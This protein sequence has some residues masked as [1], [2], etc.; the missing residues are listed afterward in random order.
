MM[1]S[2]PLTPLAQRDA[3][4]STPISTSKQQ[5]IAHTTPPASTQSEKSG[6]PATPAE[7][8]IDRLKH[9]ALELAVTEMRKAMEMGMEDLQNQLEE[10]MTVISEEIATQRSELITTGAAV[11]EAL[12]RVE[13]VETT[14]AA[15]ERRGSSVGR[16]TKVTQ[17]AWEAEILAREK[18]ERDVAES[19]GAT[20]A[21]FEALEGTIQNQHEGFLQLI[22]LCKQL[23]TSN[24]QLESRIEQCEAD[25]A[26]RVE[27]I[28]SAVWVEVKALSQ[29]TAEVEARVGK[30]ESAAT[31]S[32]P[33]SRS[34]GEEEEEPEDSESVGVLRQQLVASLQMRLAAAE[35]RVEEVEAACSAETEQLRCEVGQ[36]MD[37]NLEIQ[38]FQSMQQQEASGT[39]G[40][41]VC[42]PEKWKVDPTAQV[43]PS[44]SAPRP[45]Q[46]LATVFSPVAP[47]AWSLKG[48]SRSSVAG[49]A[50]SPA[51]MERVDEEASPTRAF[52]ESFHEEYKMIA[53][54]H[55]H[56]PLLHDH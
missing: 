9:E 53:E 30:L 22:Q 6:G 49:L 1:S 31:G 48:N 19:S 51:G 54:A 56:K 20:Q 28:E 16:G 24:E 43:T 44:P 27:A 32:P 29:R 36:L 23:K 14:A 2:H 55:H 50:V 39:G 41:V 47:E 7:R 40:F 5:P 25:A 10:E 15:S 21:R 52:S 17:E 8:V 13:L 37:F 34:R 46:D 18:L 4:V 11:T 3:N 26:R 42:P 38:K 33:Q 35:A 45:R 12:S